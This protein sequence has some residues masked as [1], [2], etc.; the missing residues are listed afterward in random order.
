M[1]LPA[2][3]RAGSGSEEKGR[4]QDD[5]DDHVEQLLTK[6]GKLRRIGRGVLDFVS[7][8]K[9]GCLFERGRQA[10]F[11]PTSHSCWSMHGAIRI[12]LW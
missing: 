9:L 8:R 12:P 11:T 6:K 2:R 7:T 3:D 5:L 10:K 4:R 1:N